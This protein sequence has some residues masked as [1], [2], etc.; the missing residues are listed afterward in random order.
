MSD[1]KI[2]VLI[3]GLFLN[4]IISIILALILDCSKVGIFIFVGDVIASILWL[5]VGS[6]IVDDYERNKI[7]NN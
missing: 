6:A 4:A 2:K 1:L 3:G 5:L 7:K